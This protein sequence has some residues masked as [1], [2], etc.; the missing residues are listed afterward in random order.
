MACGD[1]QNPQ[2]NS[3]IEVLPLTVELTDDTLVFG[4]TLEV[5]VQ[6]AGLLDPLG[7][8]VTFEGKAGNDTI[9]ELVTA[10][11]QDDPQNPGTLKLQIP[12]S[13]MEGFINQGLGEVIFDGE[14]KV[15]VEDVTG[16]FAGEGRLKGA[17]VRFTDQLQPE[18][19]NVPERIMIHL[20]SP[21][22]FEGVRFLK[23]GEGIT[24]LV[25]TGSYEADNGGTRQINTELAVDSGGER[26]QATVVWNAGLF[27]V[28]PGT[29]TGSLKPR[30][31]HNSGGPAEGPGVPI[32]VEILPSELIGFDP[33]TAS[34]G[35]RLTALGQGF[36]PLNPG[37]AQSMFFELNGSFLTSRG[38]ELDL[39]G[40]NVLRLAPDL[41]PGHT[42]A[43]IAMRT[44][45]V[46]SGQ[47]RIL[48][49]ITATPGTFT[50]SITPILI[51]ATATVSG[52]PYQGSFTI[53]PT[54]QYVFVKFLPGFSS[55][56]DDFGLRNVEPELRE[57]I[58]E[59]VRRDF[60]GVNIVF[61]DE[62]PDDFV[63]Y[64]IIEV[65][66][67]DPNGVGLLGLDNTEGKDTGNIRLDDIVGGENA[68][69]GEQGFYSFGGVFIESFVLFSPTL[70]SDSSLSSAEFD[71]I[72][73][74]FSPL[75]GGTPI[76]AGEIDDGPRR[77][78]IEETVRAFGSIIG[79]TISHEI[80]H[81]LGLSFFV[82][83]LQGPSNEFHNKFDEPNALMDSGR[84]RPFTERA[85]L[86]GDGPARFN[87]RNLDYL[88][89]ILPMP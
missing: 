73:A 21:S 31:D 86:N 48:S 19:A 29:F 61:S 66:G 72:M 7:V 8:L 33:A 51:D 55:A 75:L 25:L 67:E 87:E 68:D 77:P 35:Q 57:R 42:T 39:T 5:S 37:L 1:D 58:F 13:A 45:S 62:R 46:T 52:I 85:E 22:T 10:D 82:E 6:G 74:P 71:R 40:D 23:P 11:F 70:R 36:I 63:E 81:S 28:R 76:E 49:G 69:S 3:A 2:T 17:I 43:Q 84:E 80:G 16:Q 47:R 44:E 79:N 53:A 54:T 89:S 14:L 15:R 78:Q 83:D 4:G 41:V 18:L 27:G 24:S 64:S 50:G 30:N 65:G 59:V 88:L 9:K 60:E 32:E 26:T 12:W 56:L 38:E 34:R 20:N